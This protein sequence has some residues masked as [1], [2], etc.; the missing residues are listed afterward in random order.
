MNWIYDLILVAMFL[1]MTI[2]GW[3]HGMLSALLR[4]LGWAVALVLITTWSASWSQT[5]YADYVETPV[6]A[7]EESAIPADAIAA[8]NSGAEA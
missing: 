8:M 6:V 3:R 7:A 4:M 2:K 1:T 5:I